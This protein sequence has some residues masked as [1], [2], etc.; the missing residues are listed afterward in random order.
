MLEERSQA[1][2]EK[3]D[4]VELVIGWYGQIKVQVNAM[5]VLR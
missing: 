1:E 3:R 5:G 2:R 4:T